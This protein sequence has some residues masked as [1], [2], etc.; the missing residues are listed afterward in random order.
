MPELQSAVSDGIKMRFILLALLIFLNSC[1]QNQKPILEVPDAK[2]DEI[3]TDALNP[4][5][6]KYGISKLRENYL[7]EDDFEVRVWVAAFE[8]DG[9]ILRHFNK[10]WSAIAIKEIDCHKESYFPED[11]IYELG[12]FNLSTPKSGWKNAWQKLVEAG[13][14]ELPSSDDKSYLDGIGYTVETNRNGKYRIYFYGNPV[15]QKT[16][17]AQRMMKIGEIIADEFGLRNFKIGSLCLD[18]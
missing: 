7:L 15:H 9:F 8:T 14:F 16:E 10:T 6:E 4:I 2:T 18:K 17:E 11:K 5:T 13:I 12:K 3:L 1:F